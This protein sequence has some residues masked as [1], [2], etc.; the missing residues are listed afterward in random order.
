MSVDDIL[1]DRISNTDSVTT[2]SIGN[3]IIY[4][5]IPRDQYDNLVALGEDMDWDY[6]LTNPKNTN[7]VI[8]HGGNTYDGIINGDGSIETSNYM[9]T[10]IQDFGDFNAGDVSLV[11]SGPN[12]QIYYVPQSDVFFWDEDDCN[13]PYI[14]RR[15]DD[16]KSFLISLVL[17]P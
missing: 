1:F 12:C 15:I 13:G 17:I 16:L 5:F 2:S 14:I 4:N 9:F 3:S 6:D 7:M 11:V 8:S 10:N